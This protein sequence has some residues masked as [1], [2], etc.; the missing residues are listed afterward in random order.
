MLKYLSIFLYSA[1]W[2][3]NSSTESEKLKFKLINV[4]WI[5]KKRMQKLIEKGKWKLKSAR[6]ANVKF[7]LFIK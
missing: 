1:L 2:L 3:F 7:Y 5:I 6:K 4:S